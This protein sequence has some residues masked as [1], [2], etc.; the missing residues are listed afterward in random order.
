MDI[1]TGPDRLIRAADEI[2]Q[3]EKNLRI[4]ANDIEAVIASLRHSEDES[5]QIAATKLTKRVNELCEKIRS[6]RMT[7]VALEKIAEV[8]MRTE[9]D[10]MEYEDSLQGQ[11]MTPYAAGKDHLDAYTIS[12]PAGM[13]YMDETFERL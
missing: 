7:W 1:N 12:F 4:R 8:Y 6:V 5:M 9:S 13:T 3:A 2:S 11:R 10:I